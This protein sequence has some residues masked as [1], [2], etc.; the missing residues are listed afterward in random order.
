LRTFGAAPFALEFLGQRLGLGPVF[1]VRH[2][3]QSAMQVF[4]D[5][6][7]GRLMFMMEGR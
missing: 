3:I 7:Q 1:F 5:F 2:V 6:R 4:E